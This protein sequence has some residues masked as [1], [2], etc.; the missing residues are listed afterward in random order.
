MVVK[1]LD[2]TVEDFFRD[3][4]E[5]RRLFEA[6]LRQVERLG[7]ATI[8][9]SKSQIA[10]RRKTNFAL[11]WIPGQYLKDRPTAPLV[12]AI[13]FPERNTSPRW[14]EITEVGPKR[15]THHLELYHEK[16]IDEQ[17]F[18]WLKRAWDEAV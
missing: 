16:E 6:I 3:K 12:L 2:S 4:A 15:F 11:V 8:R 7:D 1:V 9:S 14:K 5:S 10:F 17:V 13:S 18:K